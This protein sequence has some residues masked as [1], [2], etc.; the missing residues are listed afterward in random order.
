MLTIIDGLGESSQYSRSI[1]I[2]AAGLIDISIT[3]PALLE[4]QH[5]FEMV[6]EDLNDRAIKRLYQGLQKDIAICYKESS[7][8]LK[9]KGVLNNRG[10]DKGVEIVCMQ[11]QKIR[12]RERLLWKQIKRLYEFINAT[13]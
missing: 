7:S 11:H 10:D 3:T 1:Q 5:Q 13:L 9:K 2:N 12:L 4:D 8:L 6:L